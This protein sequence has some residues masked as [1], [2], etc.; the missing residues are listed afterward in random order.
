LE[1]GFRFALKF[2]KV[3]LFALLRLAKA[4]AK[5]LKLTFALGFLP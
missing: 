2:A 1:K 4:K 3:K 5:S